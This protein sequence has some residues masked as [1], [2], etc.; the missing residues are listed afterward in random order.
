M[1]KVNLPSSNPPSILVSAVIVKVGD[2]DFGEKDLVPPIFLLIF[3]QSFPGPPIVTSQLPSTHLKVE[4]I[5]FVR[6]MYL[7]N[8]S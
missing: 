3:K 7:V 4:I 1:N 8:F 2:L 6:I 5:C